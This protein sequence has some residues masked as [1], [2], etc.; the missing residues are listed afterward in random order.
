MSNHKGDVEKK[1]IKIAPVVQKFL[2]V[3][4]SHT[5]ELTFIFICIDRLFVTNLAGS[6][7]FCKKMTMRETPGFNYQQIPTLLNICNDHCNVEALYLRGI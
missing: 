7:V 5:D 2:G 1:M 6:S 3:T 4:H